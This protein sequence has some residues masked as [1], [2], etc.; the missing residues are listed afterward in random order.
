MF[1]GRS[2]ELRFLEERMAAKGG[3]LVVIY[4]RRRIGKTELLRKFCE[5]KRH[6]FYSCTE[7][8]DA[9]QLAAF[10]E[11]VL[12]ENVP[13]SRYITSFAD[14]RQAFE[15]IAELPGDDRKILVIDEFP[16][17]VRGNRA[18][19]SI[20]Q[21]LW[22]EK[23]KDENV[24]IILCGSAMSFIEK[25]ILAEKN[26]LYGRAT[27]ILKINEMDFFD[28]SKFVPRYCPEDKIATY[29]ALGGVPH[30]LKQFNDG[31]PIC[32]NI[33]R[34]IFQRGSI[35]YSEVEFLMRQELRETSV[36][37]AI[38]EAVALGATKLNEIYQ[39]TQI[40]KT[41]LSAYLK[42]LIEL[43][44]IIR[45]FS[46]LD[47]IKEHANVQRGLYRIAD[48]FFRFWYTF[49]FPNI[50][51]L[52]AGDAEGVWR[53][54]AEPHMNRYVSLTF[55]E[56]CRQYLRR[57]NRNDALPFR[58]TKI[59]RWWNKTDELDIMAFDAQKENFLLGECKYKNS[60]FD[61][62]DLK[63]MQGKFIA[64]DS[65]NVYYVLFS[66]SGFTR[67]VI[68]V[69][70]SQNIFDSIDKRHHLYLKSLT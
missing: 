62:G 11:R 34:G 24:M 61:L 8:P 32:E 44:I 42:N 19:P 51:E 29:A 68:G 22:D 37:N 65:V 28:A 12:R 41:K 43:G 17:M 69:A 33:K 7:S 38:I 31:L 53:F 55:E 9:Q 15:S 36:Y 39:K 26:P 13:A 49:V 67:D 18:I 46:V 45:E 52:E 16:Y 20:F 2:D 47:G 50:S 64:P 21:N 27:G 58:F 23:L 60:P 6:I 57:E 48:N 70:D 54:V 10:S 56:V 4:G 35:L 63:N 30:Y 66:K 5:G 1:I 3:Q 25:E 59:G 40:E 14:W